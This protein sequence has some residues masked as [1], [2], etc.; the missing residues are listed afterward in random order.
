VRRHFLEPLLKTT[1][2]PTLGVEGREAALA[3]AIETAFDSATRRK[4]LLGREG[5]P[6]GAALVI[7]PCSGV[8]TFSMR[9]PIDVVF[10]RRD[11]RVIK[12][13]E[14]MPPGR[15]AVALGAF[16]VVEMAAGSVTRAR[17]RPGDRLVVR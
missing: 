17:L 12:I 10:A 15:V 11:G 9:F 14:S 16:A 13:R 2:A 6:E 1:R 8:H 7:A 4:G 3:A 5:L